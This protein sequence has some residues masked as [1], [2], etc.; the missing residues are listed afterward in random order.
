[1][2]SL[3]YNNGEISILWQPSICQHSGVCVRM[4]PQVYKP[5]ERPWIKIENASTE[6]LK[7]Q[8]AACP[9]GALSI[10]EE[11]PISIEQVDNG[12]QGTYT[13]MSGDTKI[14]LLDYVWSG[15]DM[16]IISHT[17]VIGRHEGKR[18]G[19]SL[20][21]AAVAYARE[22]AKKI[23]PLCPFAKSKF[24]SDHSL[25]DVLFTGTTTKGT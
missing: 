11:A 14:G 16:F 12:K 21:L 13:L 25:H 23:M 8:I 7:E 3:E 6:E 10:R 20:V 4:L 9:S 18:Y 1:M 15:E 24:D 17:E 5:K 19:T 2:S 22:H